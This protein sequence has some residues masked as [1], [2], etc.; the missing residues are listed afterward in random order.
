MIEVNKIYN[1]DCLEGMKLIDDNSIDLIVTD[2]P[3]NISRVN[4]FRTM[5]RKGIDFGEWDKNF[6]QFSWINETFRIVKKGGSLLTFNDWKNIG[7]TAKYAE[8]IGF[9]IKDMVRWRKSNP[10]PRNK[11]R[12]YITDFEVAVWLIKPKG[13]WTF[14]RQSDTYDRCEYNYSITPLSEKTGHT[15]QKPIKLMEEIIKRHS[16]ENDL[17]LDC[18]MGSGTT[19]IAAINTNRNFIGFEMDEKYYNIADNRIKEALNDVQR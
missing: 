5:G 16:N 4:N 17:I 10:M 11:D 15:T 8:S 12:R 2:P 14:N 1:Q 18:F 3:Y 13:K 6:N 7:E 9:E 19:A